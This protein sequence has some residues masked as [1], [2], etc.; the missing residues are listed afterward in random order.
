MWVTIAVWVVV[1]GVHDNEVA[2]TRLETQHAA[3]FVLKRQ[4]Q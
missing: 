4:Q 3:V 2:M 1:G